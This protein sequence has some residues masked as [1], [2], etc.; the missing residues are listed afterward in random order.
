MDTSHLGLLLIFS[1]FV[2]IAFAVLMRDEPREQVLF[3]AKLFGTFVGSAVLLG[4]LLYPL[5]L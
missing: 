5:P 2:S 1:A 3:G 4:W